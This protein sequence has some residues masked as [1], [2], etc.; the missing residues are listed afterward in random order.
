EAAVRRG[1]A[2]ALPPGRLERRI[3]RHGPIE[4]LGG[5]AA[6]ALQA[7]AEGADAGPD[8]GALRIVALG[9]GVGRQRR[10]GVAVGLGV[11]ADR[12]ER[13]GARRDEAALDRL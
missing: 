1:A 12:V 8:V 4:G 11:G 7:A 10:L 2:R 5:I 13:V 6:A 3:D 9:L